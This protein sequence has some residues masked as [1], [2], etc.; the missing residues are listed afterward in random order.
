[1]L[2]FLVF[3]SSTF[4]DLKAQCN[5]LAEHVCVYADVRFRGAVAGLMVGLSGLT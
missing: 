5:A 1:M 4:R 3:V 2:A